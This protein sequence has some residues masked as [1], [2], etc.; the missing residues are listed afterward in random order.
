MQG[1]IWLVVAWVGAA[2]LLLCLPLL[3]GSWTGFFVALVLSA[4]AV[5]LAFG[6]RGKR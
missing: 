3:M 1:S 4:G 6:K 5:L 2:I